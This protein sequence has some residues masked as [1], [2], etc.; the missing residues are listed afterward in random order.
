M[1]QEKRGAR[2][3]RVCITNLSVVNIKAAPKYN[4][5][6][7]KSTLW[8]TRKVPQHT[9]NR[10]KQKKLHRDGKENCRSMRIFIFRLYGIEF[11]AASNKSVLNY[12]IISHLNYASLLLVLV[13]V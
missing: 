8:I 3:E 12:I 1:G 11:M 2:V 6:E 13:A 5:Y 10:V 7:A 4:Y 9:W